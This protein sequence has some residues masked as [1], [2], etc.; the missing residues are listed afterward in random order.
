MLF[1]HFINIDLSY[2]LS[3]KISPWIIYIKSE[4]KF[5]ALL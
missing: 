1:V 2:L 3:K 4:Y 5:F